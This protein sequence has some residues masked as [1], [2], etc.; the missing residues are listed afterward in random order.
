MP[1]V[2]KQHRIYINVMHTFVEPLYLAYSRP[3]EQLISPA[4][5]TLPATTT[6][7]NDIHIKTQHCICKDLHG[8]K[9]WSLAEVLNAKAA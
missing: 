6:P 5:L 1:A 3:A 2:Y 7:D 8:A 9:A 4:E